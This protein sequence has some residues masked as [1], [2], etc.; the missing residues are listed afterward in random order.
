VEATGDIAI[1]K[2]ADLSA[3][4]YF[5]DNSGNNYHTDNDGF[6][7]LRPESDALG[8]IQAPEYKL[9]TSVSLDNNDVESTHI[10]NRAGGIKV[11]EKNKHYTVTAN[12]GAANFIFDG[13]APVPL[14]NQLVITLNSGWTGYEPG[15]N[16]YE[17]TVIFKDKPN[18]TTR[19][20]ALGVLRVLNV[21]RSY[22]LTVI[23]GTA[24]VTGRYAEGDI[25]DITTDE[26]R[27]QDAEVFKEWQTT[28]GGVIA[29]TGS[30]STTY[31]MPASDATV[32]AIYDE[33]PDAPTITINYA[34]RKLI[35]KDT[36]TYKITANGVTVEKTADSETIGGSIAIDPSWFGKTLTIRKTEPGEPDSISAAIDI[37]PIRPAPGSVSAIDETYA[38]FG[39]GRLTGVTAAME[40]REESADAWT[41]GTGVAIENLAP[42]VYVVRYAATDGAEFSGQELRVSIRSGIAPVWSVSLG[43]ESEINFAVK[44]Y[45][46]T[47]VP[48]RDVTVT[49]DG[50]R[51]TGSS[52]SAPRGT[53]G[54]L[55]VSLAKGEN[56]PFELT[57][58]PD[59]GITSLAPG[60]ASSFGVRPKPGF[61][62]GYYED[63]LTVANGD[64]GI[65]KTIALSFTV[66]RANILSFGVVPSFTAGKA[67][68]IPDALNS[69]DKITAKL[70]S[71]RGTVAAHYEGGEATANVTWAYTGHRDDMAE[72]AYT[73]NELPYVNQMGV[74]VFEGTATSFADPKDGNIKD[75]NINIPQLKATAYVIVNDVPHAIS[76]DTSGTYIFKSEP[77][78]YEPAPTPRAVTVY[79]QG[80]L[81]TGVLK[82]ELVGA[83]AAAFRLSPEDGVI[84]SI[85][86]VGSDESVSVGPK[87]G[88]APGVYTAMLT[89]YGIDNTDIV[90]KSYS[91]SFTVR[92]GEI[93]GFAPIP[94]VSAGAVGYGAKTAAELW[95]DNALPKEITAYTTYGDAQVPVIGWTSAYYDNAVPGSYIFTAALG[96]LPP[97]TVNPDSLTAQLAVAVS[98]PVHAEPPVFTREPE[99][100]GGFVGTKRKLTA[101][102]SVADGGDLSYQWYSNTV[103]EY[104]GGA[105][106][107]GETKSY[108]VPGAAPG[109]TYYWCEAVNENQS[110]TGEKTS[111]PSRS[112]IAEV[113]LMHAKLTVENGEAELGA[114]GEAGKYMAYEPVTI[115]ADAPPEG[116][117]FD[118]WEQLSGKN[119]ALPS[120][121][122]GQ[123]IMPE[124]DI[125]VKALYKDIPDDVKPPL[126]PIFPDNNGGKTDGEGASAGTIPADGGAVKLN[127][128]ETDGNVVIEL[129]PVKIGE[130]IANSADGAVSVDVSAIKD[131]RAVTFTPKTGLS[132]VAQAGLRVVILFPNGEIS[133][134]AAASKSLVAQA[135]GTEITIE[136]IK[137]G[138]GALTPA[139]TAALPQDAE[140]Y[141]ISIYSRGEY[142]HTYAGE[143][144][145]SV[146]YAGRLPAGAWY[147]KDDGVKEKVPSVY[148]SADKAVTFRP[149]H[150]SRYVV[151][152][153]GD[154][155]ENPFAD[156][157]LDDWFY[158]DVEYATEYGIFKGTSETT[159][160]PRAQMTRAMFVTA[161]YRMSGS[162]AVKQNAGFNDVDGES[163]YGDAVSWAARSGIVNG[164]GDNKF[165]P[166]RPITRQELVTSLYRYAV[167]NG[168]GP[169]GNW[170]SR[171]PF[172]DVADIA[173]WATEAVMWATQKGIVTGKPGN[174]FD[175]RG[176]ATRAEAA[177]ALR[178]YLF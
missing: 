79:N 70:N 174:M 11:L 123:I 91:V 163:W 118:V 93:T 129:P 17:I 7:K 165:A 120:A 158:G 33:R 170:A 127:Y 39:D 42:G 82:A 73:P 149:P 26:T 66:Q 108:T 132:D 64:N 144:L 69:L 136:V 135:E 157:A 75:G 13:G 175:P 166:D 45:G 81:S 51:P 15:A 21:T 12:S 102:A 100:L 94:S 24:S 169:T 58:V 107:A 110:A 34:E 62:V 56:S 84:A 46:Y 122:E 141:V 80:T 148:N 172:D 177:A 28:N 63:T 161:L 19:T 49:N 25:I 72:K 67:G 43:S 83:G 53:D 90:H 22:D 112:A 14:T 44:P 59:G 6:Q 35:T 99:A 31:T 119:I 114:S 9:Y 40:Y 8:E 89:V 88:L 160:E 68:E 134:N 98:S 124:D 38:G 101:E 57:E 52:M 155:W 86:A 5:L 2:A 159:F 36:A 27:N 130:I 41:A 16:D 137:T 109:V 128:K 20:A 48:R 78:G 105:P 131:A 111:R 168:T 65:S 37:K 164:V 145:V 61:A 77:Y 115:T 50:N 125:A 121:P 126:P 173:D 140:P 87:E 178:R 95:E 55:T 71:E 150:L 139:Q 147:M 85:D 117:A 18:G 146:P 152:Y 60:A 133:L 116:K 74:Y 162:P 32:T 171:I 1:V 113:T 76:L 92:R 10:K 29:A 47:A 153:A 96:Q 104:I 154:K 156:V 106:I 167:F 103:R 4:T 151:G 176:T 30:A 138:A 143:I 3:A 54:K 97:N 142:I 23:G